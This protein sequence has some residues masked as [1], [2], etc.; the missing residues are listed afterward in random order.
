MNKEVYSV[1][2]YFND[3]FDMVKRNGGKDYDTPGVMTY[4][5]DDTEERYILL[6]KDIKNIYEIF[7][8]Y[9]DRG[10]YLKLILKN[11]SYKVTCTRG[12]DINKMT[13]SDNLEL[14]EFSKE[15]I[16]V[17]TLLSYSIGVTNLRK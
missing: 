4:Y 12:K 7:Y 16:G 15:L 10:A 8:E 11:D 1:I 5:L 9:E 6:K 14:W 2:N 17:K 13:Y 3:T